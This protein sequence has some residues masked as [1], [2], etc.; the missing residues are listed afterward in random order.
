MK[1]QYL[2]NKYIA[3]TKKI[4]PRELRGSLRVASSVGF[5]ASR[6]PV[7]QLR[8]VELRGG[9]HLARNAQRFELVDAFTQRNIYIYKGII[10]I[11][12]YVCIIYI[13]MCIY[14]FIFIVL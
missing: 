12:I 2:Y 5:R 6:L 9:Q 11:C 1:N 4:G 10:Y 13:D 3:S 14:T 8:A 7:V